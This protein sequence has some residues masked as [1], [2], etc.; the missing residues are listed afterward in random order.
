VQWIMIVVMR[1]L[2]LYYYHHKDDLKWHT[3]HLRWGVA[4]R[5]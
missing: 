1:I 5:L 3:K 4:W 2:G